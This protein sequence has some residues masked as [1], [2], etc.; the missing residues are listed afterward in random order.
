MCCI[1]QNI[2]EE[3]PRCLTSIYK[4]ASYLDKYELSYLDKYELWALGPIM[5]PCCA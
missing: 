3:I 1:N 2:V 4:K 5:R